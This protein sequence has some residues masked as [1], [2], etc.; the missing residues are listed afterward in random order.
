MFLGILFILAS[1]LFGLAVLT[2]LRVKFCVEEQISIAIP[3][4]LIT[5]TLLT[6]LVSYSQKNLNFT[7]I[8]LMTIF[9]IIISLAIFKRQDKLNKTLFSS[10][11]SRELSLVALAGTLAFLVLNVNSI[12]RPTPYGLASTEFGGGDLSFHISVINS[13][14]FRSNFPPHYPVMINTPMK[15]PVPADFLSSIL[16]TSGFD[17]RSSIII[18]NLLFQVA[19][20]CLIASLAIRLTRKKYVGIFSAFMMFFAGN[21]GIIF[22]LEDVFRSGDVITW[23]SKLPTDYAGSGI[24]SLP[25]L[26]FGNPV[27]VMLM[28]Q[29]SSIMGMSIALIVYILMIHVLKKDGQLRELILAGVLTGILPTVHTHSFIAVA[30]VLVGFIIIFKKN[31]RF[32]VLLFLPIILLALPQLLN[33]QTQVSNDFFGFSAGWLGSANTTLQVY[34]YTILNILASVFVLPIPMET[35][36]PVHFFTVRCI[37][38]P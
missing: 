18:P 5:S 35:A 4:G 19:L 3:I 31:W 8:S 6:Y 11:R 23:I 7:I 12:L 25:G 1:I 32:F 29:R 24:S 10:K 28:P 30:M 22:A 16:I 34:P 38:H 17:L 21:M 27:S 14:V 13:F 26:Y 2:Y 9:L 15:Y 36:M 20:F 33:I 37:R